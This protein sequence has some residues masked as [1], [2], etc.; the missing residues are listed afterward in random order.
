MNDK[1]IQLIKSLETDLNKYRAKLH[2]L[3]I[4]L[5]ERCKEN[6]SLSACLARV[7]KVC[8][9]FH[10]F[11]ILFFFFFNVTNF[12]NIIIILGSFRNT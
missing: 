8:A 9:F 6:E 7:E 5:N 4:E 2:D 10:C 12:K 1:E 3:Q 11:F